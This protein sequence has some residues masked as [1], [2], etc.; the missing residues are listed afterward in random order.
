[1]ITI[2]FHF[3]IRLTGRKF[4]FWS[5]RKSSRRGADVRLADVACQTIGTLASARGKS[6]IDNYYTALHSLLAY[7]GSD[8][9]P[10]QLTPTLIEGWQ[11]WLLGRGVT[12]N[13]IS[14][15]MR[16]LRAVISHTDSICVSKAAF[17]NVFTGNTPTDKRSIRTA[18]IRRLAML[19]LPP[20][21][22][23][24]LARDIFLFSICALGMP[25]VDVAFLRKTQL[26]DGYI[27]YY[28]HK[29]GQR[30]R[31]KIEPPMRTII[32]IYSQ[33]ATPF[34]FPLLQ[35]GTMSE[36]ETLRSRYNRM[37]NQLG[38][39]A[40]LERRLTSYVARHSWASIAYNSNVDL[41][42]ISK[43]LGHTSSKTTQVYIRE[44]DDCRIDVANRQLLKN[45]QLLPPLP[46]GR[47]RS[48]L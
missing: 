26:A 10:G 8:V 44:I 41:T 9:T 47:R 38:R 36:Y 27:T 6:T 45:F 13:T 5:R 35:R 29:T 21:G 34:V 2:C 19:P 25:F 39:M 23:L 14:C 18:D 42:V 31:I 11:H 48:A 20:G 3:S 37:L 24:R 17:R 16:S 43:A 46:T 30:I 12:L 22:E 15:Y 4:L 33:P 7:A 1:M 40:G 28:R 32:N